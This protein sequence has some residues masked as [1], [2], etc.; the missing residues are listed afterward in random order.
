VGEECPCNIC[1]KLEL[2][3]TTKHKA[4]MVG[5]LDTPSP[6]ASELSFSIIHQKVELDIDILS[7]SLKGRTELTVNP[8]SKDL[9]EIRLNCRH[10]DLKRVT[11]NG[12]PSPNLSYQDPYSR[13]ILPWK[14]G[15][16]QHHMLR[17][18]LE[19]QFKT[20]PERELLV[21]FPKS[22]RIDE[23]DP[24]SIEAGNTTE[25]RDFASV[26]RSFSDGNALEMTQG[27]RSGLEQTLRY[28]PVTVFIEYEIMN[29]RD[30]MHFIGWEEGDLRYLHAFTRNSAVSGTACCLFPCVDDLASRPTWEI[31]IKCSKTIGDALNQLQ[32]SKPLPQVN[33]QNGLSNGLG[34]T[35]G[36]L[37][38]I[39]KQHSLTEEDLALDL[40][41]ICTGDM[42]DEVN[43]GG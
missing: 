18:K 39:V 8:F 16:N 38:D 43:A 41:V 30:G 2:I 13:A 24:Y 19:G 25:A 6:P 15:V 4:I 42:T 17:R 31:S 34:R 35:A 28:N 33:V 32:A 22:L 1:C 14:A 20:P 36:S 21:T 12:K 40:A 37:D 5:L 10:C 26:K 29:I 23:I 27:L 3:P 11:V 7:R 9:K